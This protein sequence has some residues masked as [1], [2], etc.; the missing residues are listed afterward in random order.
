[1]SATVKTFTRFALLMLLTTLVSVPAF[2]AA[3]R[4]ELAAARELLEASKYSEAITNATL[5]LALNTNLCEAYFIRGRAESLSGNREA[6]YRNYD[7][8]VA[9]D[10]N[11]AWAYYRRGGMKSWDGEPEKAVED[12]T[13]AIAANPIP[14]QFWNDRA[15][16][17]AKLGKYNEAIADLSEAIRLKPNIP[18]FRR[19]RALNYSRLHRYEEALK[20]LDLAVRLDGNDLRQRRERADVFAELSRWEEAT[21]DLN[22]II[23]KEPD[24]TTALGGRASVSA[25]LGRW[26][27]A[28]RDYDKILEVKPNLAIRNARAAVSFASGENAKALR[29]IDAYLTSPGWSAEEAPYMALLGTIIYRRLG[30]TNNATG[31]LD[32]ADKHLDHSKWPYPLLGWMRGNVPWNELSTH[33]SEN[34]KA[35]E[36]HT[37]AALAET[38]NTSAL[39]HLSWVRDH[40]S[41]NFTEYFLAIAELRRLKA[42]PSP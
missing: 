7:A 35:T 32:A 28:L 38:N 41:R 5:A 22:F 15:S 39:E 25:I 26:D 8:A 9:C 27:A 40:G 31:L 18:F 2:G 23:R 6:A 11:L 14:Q 17:Y 30:E 1:M 36:I 12:Y 29:Q 34:G 37:Y 3:G 10:T 42:T 20:D 33:T 4:V 19:N 24:N 13:R 16:A 21:A